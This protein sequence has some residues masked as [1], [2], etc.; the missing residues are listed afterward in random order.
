MDATMD[1]PRPV[2]GGFV[3]AGT[4]AA[5]EPAEQFRQQLGV[6]SRPVVGDGQFHPWPGVVVQPRAARW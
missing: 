2:T 1:S 6:D 4:V 5:D 3:G